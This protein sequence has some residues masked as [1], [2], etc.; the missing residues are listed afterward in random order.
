MKGGSEDP[1]YLENCYSRSGY[2]ARKP[3]QKNRQR[4]TSVLQKNG[5]PLSNFDV[6]SLLDGSLMEVWYAHGIEVQIPYLIK[7]GWFIAMRWE[8]DSMSTF[9]FRCSARHY[10]FQDFSAKHFTLVS[11]LCVLVHMRLHAHLCAYL[12]EMLANILAISLCA[13][14]SRFTMMN[15]TLHYMSVEEISFP[16]SFKTHLLDRWTRLKTYCTVSYC[17]G[18]SIIKTCN[19]NW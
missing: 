9:D 6:A 3:R 2:L 5:S 18:T 11:Y 19:V 15:Q 4:G 17:L 13:E 8:Y 14:D 1:R 12:M 16:S 7:S 10:G